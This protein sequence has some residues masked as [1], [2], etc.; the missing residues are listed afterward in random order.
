MTLTR[1]SLS[2]QYKPKKEDKFSFGLWHSWESWVRSLW[3]F[4]AS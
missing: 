1:E 2:D 3:R 4:C